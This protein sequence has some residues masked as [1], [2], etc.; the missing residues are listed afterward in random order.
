MNS[1]LKKTY[2]LLLLA[3]VSVMAA[4]AQ[5]EE[6]KLYFSW[7]AN[8]NEPIGGK[9]TFSDESILTDKEVNGQSVPY[10]VAELYQRPTTLKQSE[11]VILLDEPIKKGDIISFK[12]FFYFDGALENSSLDLEIAGV[13]YPID[14]FN[15]ILNTD[16]EPNTTKKVLDKSCKGAT[17]IK[18]KVNGFRTLYLMS[19]SIA[20]DP[21]SMD[22]LSV[23][24]KPGS[25]LEIF[26]E[27]NSKISVTTNFSAGYISM[28]ITDRDDDAFKFAADLESD[29]Q[30]QNAFEYEFKENVILFEGHTYDVVFQAWENDA[31]K[32]DTC[33]IVY[34]GA[35]V[36]PYSDVT[37]DTQIPGA[38]EDI[39]SA[40]KNT[41]TVGFSAEA[42]VSEVELVIGD[43]VEEIPYSDFKAEDD[44]KTQW[45]VTV[46][47]KAIA[48]NLTFTLRIYA[49]DAQ[50]RQIVSEGKEYV[51]VTFKCNVPKPLA[52]SPVRGTVAKLKEF[53]LSYAGGIELLDDSAQISLVKGEEKFPAGTLE[54]DGENYVYTLTDSVTAVG[55]YRLTI[56]AKMFKLGIGFASDSLAVDY[57]IP[58]SQVKLIDQI[59]D[60]EVPITSVSDSTVTVVFSAEANVSKVE[61][62][63]GDVVEEITDFKAVDDNVKTQW[64]VTV[65]EKVIVDNVA[66]TLQIYATDAD[67]HTIGGEESNEYATASF[68][69][70]VPK[71]LTVVPDNAVPDSNEEWEE[72]KSFTL[73]YLD[74]E[75]ITLINEQAKI[76]LTKGDVIFDGKLKEEKIGNEKTGKF[77][78]T[79]DEYVSYGGEYQLNIPAGMFKLG[80]EGIVNDEQVVDYNVRDKEKDVTIAYYTTDGKTSPLNTLSTFLIDF[81]PGG[82]VAGYIN[83]AYLS[84]HPI[85]LLN[86]KNEEVAK[87]KPDSCQIVEGKPTIFKCSFE[88][89]ILVA[90]DYFLDV[91]GRVFWLS[92]DINN[93][94]YI[95][96]G[97]MVFEITVVQS[98]KPEDDFGPI[99]IMPEN[100]STVNTLS[101]TVIRFE[102]AFSVKVANGDKVV[103]DVF[104][105][106]GNG[107][108]GTNAVSTA[109]LTKY[110]N[111]DGL[112]LDGRINMSLCFE[113]AI[114]KAGTYTTTIPANSL[115][116][117][118]DTGVKLYFDR[119]W[120]F[121]YTVDP[122]SGIEDIYIPVNPSELG[123]NDFVQVYNLQ[124]ILVRQGK[125]SEA[126][127][128]LKGL[129]IVNGYKLLIK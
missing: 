97:G 40:S 109:V 71:V 93:L 103:C 79:L 57:T 122:N 101:R 119:E 54:K 91:P 74:G 19:V 33:K 25:K 84:T 63:I 39:T 92:K 23:T 75:S 56:P 53:T 21:N 37:L 32:G 35:S 108:V 73:S 98:E 38:N 81:R 114:T 20:H 76:T 107:T 65:P 28:I 112:N 4:F 9:L 105:V 36:P 121:T 117:T 87:I 50:D 42:N 68:K 16:I 1:I 83:E 82:Y 113:P 118:Y 115:Y 49:T 70:N 128:G 55:T 30:Q 14:G 59:P 6:P 3:F 58:N 78:F 106:D 80:N 27:Y 123:E 104:Y 13:H 120:K 5:S 89:P 24:P 99:T 15:N 96:N 88:K 51:E 124:G 61:L 95:P 90:G 72:L 48:D 29:K 111:S 94:K 67:G 60:T 85:R 125:L 22:F 18:L 102:D 69:C 17:E 127:N 64:A 100:E 62:V 31:K 34:Y 11:I 41:V 26:D 8:K 7:D 110:Y 44:A 45:L 43:V 12:G 2:T 129:Y 52:V 10:K 126:L 116:I 77:I 47:E 86:Y 66:F 46:P